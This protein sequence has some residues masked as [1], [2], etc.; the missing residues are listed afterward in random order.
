[1]TL[2]EIISDVV[3]DEGSRYTNYANDPGG[4]TKYGITIPAFTE[5]MGKQMTADDISCIN[6]ETAKA[7]Y[8]YLFHKY[9]VDAYNEILHH[10]MFDAIVNNGFGGASYFLQ[11][12]INALGIT[13]T[14]DSDAGPATVKA[15]NS[16]DPKQLLA[17]MI[18]DREIYYRQEAAR[19]PDLK[20]DLV[21]WLAR[22]E[23]LRVS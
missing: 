23:R 8:T 2:D 12:A 15:A 11:E 16:L 17:K 5:F 6:L 19:D 4:P 3:Q 14:I 13:V 20:G 1:M 18:D 10:A 9:N 22:A 21:G 7:F